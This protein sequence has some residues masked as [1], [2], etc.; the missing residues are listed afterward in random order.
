MD[1]YIRKILGLTDKNF[2]PD[3]DLLEVKYENH[4]E[5]YII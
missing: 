2:I 1:I 3:E 4:K 5:I